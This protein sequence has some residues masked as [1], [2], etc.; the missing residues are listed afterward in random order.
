M[1]QS[2]TPKRKEKVKRA[3]ICFWLFLHFNHF[4][5]Y[6]EV[7]LYFLFLTLE[8]IGELSIIIIILSS[9]WLKIKFR[10]K[11]NGIED[12]ARGEDC[13]ARGRCWCVR[14]Q[15]CPECW[16]WQMASLLRT[17]LARYLLFRVSGEYNTPTIWQKI[18]LT[19][20][21]CIM[22]QEIWYFTPHYNKTGLERRGDVSLHLYSVWRTLLCSGSE[23]RGLTLT[24]KLN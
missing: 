18:S 20:V 16:W 3:G 21:F 6:F 5:L 9:L 2:K 14:L 1:F 7:D 17:I 4:L 15:F 19:I 12:W 10:K 23:E 13:R 8:A 24:L 11:N 22:R